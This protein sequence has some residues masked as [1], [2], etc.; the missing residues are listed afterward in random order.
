MDLIPDQDIDQDTVD[1]NHESTSQCHF[2]LPVNM[3]W[4][5]IVFQFPKMW[6]TKILCHPAKG[7]DSVD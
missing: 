6:K 5:K 3:Y 4:L 7:I 1:V 2:A